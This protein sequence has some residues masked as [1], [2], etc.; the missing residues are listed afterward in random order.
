[1]SNILSGIAYILFA[2]LV[3]GLLAGIDRKITAHMQRRKGPPLL[4]SFYDVFKLCS[5]QGISVNRVQDFYVGG[6][7]LFVIISGIFF[8]THGD[9]LLVV[10]TLTLAS[11]CLIVAAYSSNSPY[12]Q[13]GAERELLQTMSYEPMLL[14]MSIGFYLT[15]GTFN[16]ADIVSGPQIGILYMPG[17]FF[18]LCYIL[19]IKFRKSPFD[20]SMSH[21]AHQELIK[22]IATEFSGRTLA[23]VEV[24]HWY[25]N[26]FLLGFVYLY[27]VWSAPYSPL[28]GIAACAVVFVLEI[29]IDNCCSRVKWQR[30]LTSSWLVSLVAGFVNL[31]VLMS[32]R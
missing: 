24:A 26:I 27:F 23:M 31:L 21:E 32:L 13:L 22:G 1:M 16:L 3:G 18:G 10:F 17:L 5:K 28:I 15:F 2:P 30:V 8:F 25:E 6:F 19:I 29:L 4:Q 20:L 11:V 9:I 7:L 12:S 14:M